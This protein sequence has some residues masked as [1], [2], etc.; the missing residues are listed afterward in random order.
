MRAIRSRDGPKKRSR[1]GAINTA[2][3]ASLTQ[4]TD[5]VRTEE[6]KNKPNLTTRRIGI[7]ADVDDEP[8]TEPDHP[9][10]VL[11]AAYGGGIVPKAERWQSDFIM[12]IGVT[13]G[14]PITILRAR[15][16]I[17]AKRIYPDGR[18]VNYD[19]E[20][21][22]FDMQR[23]PVRNLDDVAIHLTWLTGQPDRA[24]VRGDIAG[25]VT[26]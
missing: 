8:W 21:S 20:A 18:I 13:E 10:P 17:L 22:R 15:D 14:D 16:G 23:V 5:N 7:D 24:V 26:V 19:K 25:G 9:D 2:T 11:D 3:A 1:S 12:P 4:A 6:E